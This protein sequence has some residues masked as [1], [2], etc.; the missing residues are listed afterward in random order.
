MLTRM[1]LA[2][3]VE[4]AAPESRER[5]RLQEAEAWDELHEWG[6]S[7]LAGVVSELKGFYVKT[8]QI[9]ASRPDLFPPPYTRK[10]AVFQDDI[11]PMPLALVVAV[12]EQELLGGRPIASVFSEFDPVPLG[13]ASVAQAHRAVLA[14]N[15]Q[16]VC[17]KVQRPGMEQLMLSDVATVV[18]VAQTL[19][20]KFPVDYYTVFSE[21][22]SQLLFEFD[23]EREAE[24]MAR[25]GDT[26]AAFP[27]GAPVVTPRP[28]QGLVCRRVLTMDYI[29][30]RPL[31]KL[32]AEM[33]ERGIAPSGLASS[34]LAGALLR[35]LT[36]AFGAMLFDGGYF[37]GTDSQRSIHRHCQ[38]GARGSA[39][40]APS[41]PCPRRR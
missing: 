13:S 19:R 33:A 22:Q 3:I 36:D 1:Q 17:V 25:I 30:G 39:A 31:T 14:S 23:F 16:E 28:V 8:C 4:E 29:R 38:P 6:S 9:I 35:G 21:L 20:G 34:A 15:G 37:H 41:P 11:P 10:L 12:V 40:D 24:S 27:G 32:A 5:F 26:L 2:R 7:Q 18:Q